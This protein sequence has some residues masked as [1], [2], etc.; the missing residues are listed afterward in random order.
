MVEK[1]NLAFRRVYTLLAQTPMIHFQPG[2]PGAALRPSEVKPKLDRY[3][4]RM[5]GNPIPKAWLVSD[6]T[7][8][9]NYQMRI[10]ACGPDKCNGLTIRDC[11][12]YFANMGNSTDAKDLVFRDCML[13]INCFVPDLLE[14][15]DEHIGSFFVLHNFGTR[16]SKGFGG[17]LVEG[18]DSARYIR[19]TVE[20]QCPHFFYT[21]LRQAP[22]TH[23][24]LNHAYAVYTVLK[25]GINLGRNRFIR[26]Y[27][28]QAFLAMTYEGQRVGSDKAFI[29]SSVLLSDR[30]HPNESRQ[31]YTSFTF[32][33]A[34][35]GLAEQYV[36]RDSIRNA[37]TRLIRDRR[38]G[39][40]REDLN[41]LKVKV[42]HFEGTQE[43]SGSLQIPIESIEKAK[44]IQRFQS[45]ILIKI[46]PNRIFF[47]LNDT[48]K[49]MLGKTFLLVKVDDYDN[50]MEQTAGDVKQ[51][52]EHM[53]YI[54]T[55]DTFDPKAFVD[56]FVDFF[57][58]PAIKQKLRAFPERGTRPKPPAGYEMREAADLILEQGGRA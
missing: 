30:L 32:I 22:D 33:R 42:A 13:E 40:M 20:Q 15:I 56:G 3:L 28:R 45:P 23:T 51:Q 9:L 35:L 14:Y 48:W 53:P 46:T 54:K 52:L 5:Y 36:F 27:S 25:N 55:P 21:T 47:I 49:E 1:P 26:G 50:V 34:M 17:F 2:Q 57:N 37:G 11:K 24:M 12:A 4:R 38:T 44:G 8:A 16:Q 6:K 18:C 41:P 43:L 19:E 10:I 58:S 31:D 39:E 29:K 7:Q